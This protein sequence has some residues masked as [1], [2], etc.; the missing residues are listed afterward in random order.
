[1]SQLNGHSPLTASRAGRQCA[2]VYRVEAVGQA[3]ARCVTLD[4]ACD[5]VRASA[6]PFEMLRSNDTFWLCCR[7]LRDGGVV[8]RIYLKTPTQ[9]SP[10]AEAAGRSYLGVRAPNPEERERAPESAEHLTPAL[11]EEEALL[12]RSPKGLLTPTAQDVSL[13][14]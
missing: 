1:M 4:E 2:I 14:P 6:G 3:I 11:G 8:A 12:R 5:H 7:D 13:A 10:A 9:E